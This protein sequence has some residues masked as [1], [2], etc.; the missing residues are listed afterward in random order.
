MGKVMSAQKNVISISKIKDTQ[1]L[2]SANTNVYSKTRKGIS[3][4]IFDNRIN[5]IMIKTIKYPAK[6]Q[7]EPTSDYIEKS[8]TID[9]ALNERLKQI[10]V[11]SSNP[12]SI[13]LL[14]QTNEDNTVK[15]FDFLRSPLSSRK[16]CCPQVN[17][18]DP[19]KCP[20]H[21]TS[22]G[23]NPRKLH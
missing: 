1:V 6:L 12:V 22:N 15:L 13:R 10:Y 17:Y 8:N 4:V 21:K 11:T 9:S 16:I 5:S 20:I 23:W 14:C 2:S 18:R 19:L 3:Y 7:N